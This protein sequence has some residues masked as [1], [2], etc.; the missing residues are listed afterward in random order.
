MN[1]INTNNILINHQSNKLI[2]YLRNLTINFNF[3]L[4]II[5]K[6]FESPNI[7]FQIYD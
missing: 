1:Y 3:M 7:E 6:I 5:Q 4:L 2:L